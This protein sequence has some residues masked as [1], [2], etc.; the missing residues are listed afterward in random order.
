MI[1]AFN[2]TV[3]PFDKVE[4]DQKADQK[5]N[6]EEDLHS[7]NAA[8]EN[9]PLVVVPMQEMVVMVVNVDTASSPFHD[10]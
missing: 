1:P 4:A 7:F 3:S 6:L 8:N 5:T 9:V 2:L 10:P